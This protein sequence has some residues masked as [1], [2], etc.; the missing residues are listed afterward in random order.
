MDFIISDIGKDKLIRFKNK[1]IRIYP[2][3]KT[4]SG[5]IYKLVEDQ[6]KKLDNIYDV[7][8]VKVLVDKDI[9]KDITYIEI[10]YIKEWW[11]EDFIITTGF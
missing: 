6:P 11:G 4:W 3:I 9:A 1:F 5:I 10:D 2:N 8:G 7:F